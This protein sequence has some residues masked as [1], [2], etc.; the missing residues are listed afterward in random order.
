MMII[1]KDGFCACSSIAQFGTPNAGFLGV[2]RNDFGLKY[3]IY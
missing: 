3:G 1:S 2:V